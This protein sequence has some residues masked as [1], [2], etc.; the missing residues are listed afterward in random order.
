MEK[1]RI[2]YIQISELININECVWKQ[3]MNKYVPKVILGNETMW[4]DIFLIRD[5]FNDK[6]KI[7]R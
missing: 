5:F 3:G 4:K 7:N 1:T 6:F 2:N